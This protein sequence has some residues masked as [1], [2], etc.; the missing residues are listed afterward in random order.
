MMRKMTKAEAQLRV[1][2]IAGDL[3]LLACL[4]AQAWP[5][6]DEARKVGDAASRLAGRIAR[7]QGWGEEA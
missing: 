4:M 5:D 2:E 1:A 3:S 6:D 7:L